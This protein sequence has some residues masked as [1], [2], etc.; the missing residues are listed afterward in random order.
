MGKNIVVSIVLMWIR[1]SDNSSFVI[2]YFSLLKELFLYLLYI[3]KIVAYKHM[4][5]FYKMYT[6]MYESI[7]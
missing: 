5:I 6:N 1:I 7:K 3:L 4:D 2:H